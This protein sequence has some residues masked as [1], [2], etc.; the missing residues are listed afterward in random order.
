MPLVRVNGALLVTV[1]ITG[2]HCHSRE[3]IYSNFEEQSLR[4][5]SLVW[6]LFLVDLLKQINPVE[7][8]CFKEYTS[9]KPAH[10]PRKHRVTSLWAVWAQAGSKPRLSPSGAAEWHPSALLTHCWLSDAS[11]SGQGNEIM[12]QLPGLRSASPDVSSEDHSSS[13]GAG[14]AVLENRI[15]LLFP[16]YEGGI[17][18]KPFT[19]V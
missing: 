5:V 14:S 16:N 10:L 6:Y 3:V 4:W 12:E 13:E 8:A 19:T 18:L 11:C 9:V 2:Y 15:Q 17:Y 7:P 1:W